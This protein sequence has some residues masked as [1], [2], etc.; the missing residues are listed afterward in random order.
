M[1]KVSIIV[2]VYNVSKYLKR[3]LDSLI[4]QTLEDIEIIVVDD[5][6]KDNSNDILKKYS[7]FT[8]I[9]I[10]TNKVNKGIGYT[11][12]RGLKVARGKYIA[13]I[14]GDD[15]VEEN[16]FEKMYTKAEKDDLDLVVCRFHKL[17]EH[18][19]GTYEETMPKYTIPY[20][21][22]TSLAKNPNLL[23]DINLAPWN[24]LYRSSLFNDI[25]FPENLKYE[26][27]IVVIKSMIKAKKIG[28]IEDK[29]NYYIVRENSESTIIDKR[30]FDIIDIDNQIYQELKKQ[31]YY[32]EIKDY[33]EK[34][35]VKSLIFYIH[36][37]E[38]QKDISL[39]NDFIKA[40]ERYLNE[41]FMNWQEKYSYISYLKE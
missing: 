2:P 7:D 30:V 28:L 10:L 13:F 25:R 36:Q 21:S 20:F 31:K 41:H 35:I 22:N 17:V 16:M 27:A 18:A 15:Y 11:R 32:N 37:Q 24:K 9:K 19:D 8:Q 29:L 33:V 26:D 12:N 5:C 39:A 4:N 14:D 1:I 40:A 3:C 34:K 23:L 38:Y 6:S